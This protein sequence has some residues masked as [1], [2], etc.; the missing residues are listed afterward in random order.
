MLEEYMY[1][2]IPLKHYSG[3]KLFSAQ[4]QFLRKV[5]GK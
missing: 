3:P 1:F 2:K 5:A 4:Y